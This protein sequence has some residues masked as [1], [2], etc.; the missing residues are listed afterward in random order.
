MD[1]QN[2]LNTTES[3][4]IKL[5]TMLPEDLKEELRQYVISEAENL[6]IEKELKE[7]LIN[8]VVSNMI[9]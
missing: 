3:L 9:K 4:G 1:G 2:K 6:R 5:Y 8:E 7:K